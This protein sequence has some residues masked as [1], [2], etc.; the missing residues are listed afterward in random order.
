MSIQNKLDDLNNYFTEK[1][2]EG[3][4]EIIEL[5][6]HSAKLRIKD[7]EDCFDFNIWLK[8]QTFRP[9]GKPIYPCD[10][11]AA[12]RRTNGIPG[13]GGHKDNLCRRYPKPID[14]Q[15]VNSRVRFKNSNHFKK[16]T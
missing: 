3:N 5:E 15:L 10:S 12:G 2:C 7:G 16:K 8:R 9:L 6:Y 1:I 13:I 4:F 11:K 14:R